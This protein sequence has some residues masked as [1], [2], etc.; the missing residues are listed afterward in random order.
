M[1]VRRCMRILCGF[2]RSYQVGG[3]VGCCSCDLGNKRR[4]RPARYQFCSFLLRCSSIRLGNINGTFREAPRSQNLHHCP[5]VCRIRISIPSNNNI[6]DNTPIMRDQRW[7]FLLFVIVRGVQLLLSIICL[8]LSAYV[9]SVYTDW[10]VL[11]LSLSQS[12]L[13]RA[14]NRGSSGSSHSVLSSR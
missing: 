5:Y 14:D 3:R 7:P 4:L 8:A 2:S 11:D 6:S 10:Y 12:P 13:L 9:T 1:D